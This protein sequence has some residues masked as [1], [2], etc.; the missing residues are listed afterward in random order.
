MLASSTPIQ[1][2]LYGCHEPEK[3]EETSNEGAVTAQTPKRFQKKTVPDE[4]KLN[5]YDSICLV[6]VYK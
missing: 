2:S 5:Y 6:T 3:M 4:G 1:T